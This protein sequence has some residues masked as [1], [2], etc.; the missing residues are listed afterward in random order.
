LREAVAE[1]LVTLDSV[2]NPQPSL[3]LRWE[4]QNS[5]RRWQFWLRPGVSFHDGS[6]LTSASVV[7]ALSPKSENAFPWRVVR[8]LNDSV[9]IE[10]DTPIPHLPE[11]LTQTP[12][13]ITRTSPEGTLVGT[14]K[15]KLQRN[16]P[17]L[18]ALDATE[19]HWQGRAYVNSIE[20]AGGR[21]LREQWMDVGVGRADIV[22]VPAEVLRRAQQDHMRVLSQPGA[23]LVAVVVNPASQQLQDVVLRQALAESIDRTAL[24][25]FVFQKQG[26]ATA[27]LLPAELT[28][29]RVLFPVAQNIARARELRGQRQQALS[30]MLVYDAE[31]PALQLAAERVALNARDGGINLQASPR[32]AQTL[33][34]ADLFVR[35]IPVASPDPAS[36]LAAFSSALFGD[37]SPVGDSIESIYQRERNLL[38]TYRV[39]PLLHLPQAFAASERLK[40][41]K[42]SPTGVPVIGDLWL[43]ERK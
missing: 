24:A 9:I 21:P 2:G 7:E 25:N 4:S 30:L 35:R 15:F 40:N 37:S 22:D 28:G 5:D 10:A 34:R 33:A 23:E 32:S 41:W 12:F 43:E 29:Y 31:D 27:T 13:A 14:G 16:A 20:I 6:P 39:I 11:L 18:L 1:T 8:A 38:S 3:A 26:T 17:K 19:D 42:L 36:A